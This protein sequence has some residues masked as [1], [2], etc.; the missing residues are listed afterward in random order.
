MYFFQK[1]KFKL[2]IGVI[3]LV[4]V[5]IM[6]TSS[7][8]GGR[9]PVISDTVNFII[10][11]FQKA[12]NSISDGVSGFFATLRSNKNYIRENQELK[13]QIATLEDKIRRNDSFS[14]ENARLRKLLELKEKDTEREYI[15]ADVVSND[16]TNWS[17]TYLV[18]KGL[19]D[20]VELNCA[21]VTADGVV[22]YVSE[23]GRTWSKIVSIID[24]SASVGATITRLNVN[25]VVSGDLALSDNGECVMNYLTKDTNVEIGDYAVTSGIG[26][27]YPDG[28]Y[29]GKVVRL[30][31]GVSGLS[32][33]AIIDPGVDFFDLS[34]VMIIKKH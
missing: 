23:V 19:I 3:T 30:E 25:A 27:I 31:E 14:V 21:V 9:I 24:S 2:I 18:D 7:V 6:A 4:L 15:V 8:T 22:G 20:G 10:S 29:I 26:D 11:P 13:K 32:Q 16:L 12:A 1:N 17:K 34:E 5:V 28:L 33:A